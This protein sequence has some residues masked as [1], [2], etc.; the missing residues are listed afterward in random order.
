VAIDEGGQK[1]QDNGI[2]KHKVSNYAS[3]KSG[4]AKL[5]THNANTIA[6]TTYKQQHK[7]LNTIAPPVM[8]SYQYFVYNNDSYLLKSKKTGVIIL[9]AFFILFSVMFFTLIFKSP[10]G[11][12]LG[13]T[14][15]FLFGF[16]CIAAAFTKLIFNKTAQTIERTGI[17]SYLNK[18]YHF[19]DFIRIET[20]RIYTN[21]IYTRTAVNLRFKNPESPDKTDLLTIASLRTS[22]QV[23]QFI[24]EFHQITGLNNEELKPNRQS[25]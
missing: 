2:L 17:L 18:H 21:F 24:H 25:L 5:T 11:A 7:L 3:Q 4:A 22:K 16:F 19:K 23:E 10:I 15:F 1:C 9:G 6:F 20:V 12:F 8:L 14:A 13:G